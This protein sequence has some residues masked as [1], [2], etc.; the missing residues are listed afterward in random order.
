M[1]K[2]CAFVLAGTLLCL[3]LPAPAKAQSKAPQVQFVQTGKGIEFKDGV[4]TLKELPLMTVF[5]SDR[6]ERLTGQLRNDLF[7]RLWNEGSNSFRNDPPN[8]ALSVFNPA[9]QPMQAIVMLSNPR[10]D[11][12][13]ILYDARVLQGNIPAQG[14]ESTLFID[15][16][17][18]PC[19]SGA[20]NPAYSSYPCWAATAFSHGR[21]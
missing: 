4:L 8:A 15:G 19:N 1:M 16:Y 18:T 3:T 14:S 6:P 11:G 21:Q 13:N 10:I 20:N 12:R 9:G 5:F 17:D 2:G 7:V